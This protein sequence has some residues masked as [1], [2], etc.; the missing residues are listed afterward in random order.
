MIATTCASKIIFLQWVGPLLLVDAEVS[1]VPPGVPGIYLLHL[2]ALDRGGY[3]VLYAGKSAD[4]RRRLA[5][6]LATARA[7]LLICAAHRGVRIYFS[8]APVQRAVLRDRIESG[9]V[10]AL[11]PI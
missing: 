11:Q 6:H 8:A 5:D 1:R 3:P 10:R 4:L 9:L 7:K 2:F